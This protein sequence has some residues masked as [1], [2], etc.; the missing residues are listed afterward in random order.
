MVEHSINTGDS[1][2]ARQH[3]YRLPHAY[4]DK[5]KA[6]LDRMLV[7][8]II[9]PSLSDYSAPIP[10]SFKKDGFL[11]LCVNYRRLN[12]VSADDT[13]PVPQTKDSFQ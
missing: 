11:R 8:R 6:E 12:N 1:K 9:E 2:P 7:Q 5:V 3:A 10:L 13:Y 4:P